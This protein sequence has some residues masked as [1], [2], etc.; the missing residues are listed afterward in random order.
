MI[1]FQC[2]HTFHRFGIKQWFNWLRLASS[3]GIYPRGSSSIQLHATQ[4]TPAAPH[5]P[6]SPTSFPLRF[7]RSHRW[8]IDYFHT[9]LVGVAGLG[10]RTDS[11][12]LTGGCVWLPS[13]M[14]P[15][16]RTRSADLTGIPGM[17]TGTMF[18]GSAG[19][20]WLSCWILMSAMCFHHVAAQGKDFTV[21]QMLLFNIVVASPKE[22]TE[23]NCQLSSKS[24]WWQPD[25]LSGAW[26]DALCHFI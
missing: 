4:G 10:G 12:A 13:N 1:W 25:G 11:L 24:P 8:A 5:S 18:G 21:T 7:T 23:V 22:A 14:L 16:Q 15:K 26:R 20:K 9:G 17:P 3:C 6:R 2:S 19:L